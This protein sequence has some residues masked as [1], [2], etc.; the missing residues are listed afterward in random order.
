MQY[1]DSIHD[2]DRERVIEDAR[3]RHNIALQ[4]TKIARQEQELANERSK[5]YI[6]FILLAFAIVILGV[7]WYVYIR[8][9]RLYV[10]I[11]RQ[12]NEFITR[13]KDL[14]A[15]LEKAKSASTDE[16]APGE[17]VSNDSESDLMNRFMSLMAEDK[18]YK[19]SS[20][21]VASVAEKLGTNRTYLS[22][23]INESTGKTFNQIVNGYRIKEAIALISDV[24]ADMPL[25]QVCSEAGFSSTSTFYSLFQNFTG[26]TPAKYRSQIKNL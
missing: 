17:D 26:L 8:K 1:S 16:D 14:L 15:Q 23:T 22:R 19:D 11:V 5:L 2:I 7:G 12:N 4:E 18:L 21:T 9:K 24:E 25:K 10:A 13:E 3:V 6:L 20:L